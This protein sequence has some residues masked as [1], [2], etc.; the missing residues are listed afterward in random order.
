MKAYK[1]AHSN[2]NTHLQTHTAHTQHTAHTLTH[3]HTHTHTHS[4]RHIQYTHTSAHT[5]VCA[6]TQ[7]R[8]LPLPL[9]DT[10]PPNSAMQGYLP[11]TPS[12]SRRRGPPGGLCV[13]VCACASACVCVYVCVRKYV[14]VQAHV[15]AHVGSDLVYYGKKGTHASFVHT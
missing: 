3:T 7:A 5:H 13:C 10:S 2:T 14:T 6:H 4:H 8:L 9:E 15:C 1:S 12:S 11:F